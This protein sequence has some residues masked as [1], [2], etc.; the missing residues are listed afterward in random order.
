MC[1][2]E[3]GETNTQYAHSGTA[4][5]TTIQSSGECWGPNTHRV[6]AGLI[7]PFG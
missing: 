2:M 1:V 5:Q 3:Y 6:S 4:G 7:G